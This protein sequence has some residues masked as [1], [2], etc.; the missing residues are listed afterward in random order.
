MS[1]ILIRVAD[2]VKAATRLDPA[3]TGRRRRDAG[4]MIVEGDRG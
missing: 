2:N 3:W 1:A 4:G